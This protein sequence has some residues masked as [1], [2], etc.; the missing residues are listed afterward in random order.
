MLT[1]DKFLGLNIS[2]QLFKYSYNAPLHLFGVRNLSQLNYYLKFF[3]TSKS[4][5]S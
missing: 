5:N 4:L 2:V 1:K 3:A